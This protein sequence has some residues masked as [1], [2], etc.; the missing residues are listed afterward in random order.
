MNVL[1]QHGFMHFKTYDSYWYRMP[2]SYVILAQLDGEAVGGIRLEMGKENSLLP[3]EKVLSPLFPEVL[4]IRA[5]NNLGKVAE[6]CSLWNSKKVSGKNLSMFLSR[7][8]IAMASLLDFDTIIS[9]NATYTFRIPKD[10]GCTMI[11]DIGEQ[12]YFNYPT[13]Q[14][15]AALWLHTDL[16]DLQEADQVAKSRMLSL[17]KNR[18]QSFKEE[19]DGIELNIEYD[20]QV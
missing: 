9:F 18:K 5:K 1:E 4:D 16:G 14:F 3:Y 11:H 10:V 15:R 13:N 12:G 6:P 20:L 17:R 8:S 7:A 2:N 19:Y